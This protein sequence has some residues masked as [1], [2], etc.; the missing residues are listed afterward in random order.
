MAHRGFV[1]FA[2]DLAV[3]ATDVPKLRNHEMV[4]A[5]YLSKSYW[6]HTDNLVLEM[7]MPM[8]IA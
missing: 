7:P 1:T 8:A 6:G 2:C 5:I 4:E 3:L